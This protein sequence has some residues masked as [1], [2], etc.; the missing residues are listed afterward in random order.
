MDTTEKSY[1]TPS[2]TSSNPGLNI[3]YPNL[4]EPPIKRAAYSDRTAWIMALMSKL[5]YVRFEDSTSIGDALADALKLITGDKDPT[6]QGYAI[7]IDRSFSPTKLLTILE[8]VAGASDRSDNRQYLQDSL[9]ELN[10][11]LVNYFSVSI[12]L[13]ADTQAFLA[14]LDSPGR[15]PFL[16]LAFRGTE[17]KKPTD[18]KNDLQAEPQSLGALGGPGGSIF[19]LEADD[20]TT[21]Q[22]QWPKV[23]VHPGFWTAFNAVKSEIVKELDREELKD[24]P[25]YITGHSLGGALAVVATYALESDRIAAAYTFGGPRV[26]NLQFGQRIKPPVYRVINASDI[27]PRLPPGLLVD[28]L[29]LFFKWLVFVPYADKIAVFLE[30]FRGYRHY[31][32]LRYLSASPNSID[33]KTGLS[34]FPSLIVQ[35]NP[36]QLLRWFWLTRRWIATFGKAA[37]QDHSIDIYVNKLLYWAHV[38][39]KT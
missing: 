32:D 39:S 6:E 7:R 4:L 18:I 16:V 12:P 27:V 22:E 30:R 19:T 26:G 11:T 34:T 9:N 28:G 10:F 31:G 13:I 17:V 21:A 37:I 29:T 38:R 24:L 1:V 25:L 14:K 33:D 3:P 36:P 8:S 23:K 2:P 20:L 5:A 15:E 35:A